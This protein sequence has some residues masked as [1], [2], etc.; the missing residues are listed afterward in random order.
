MYNLYSHQQV[1]APAR[2]SRCKDAMAISPTSC[3][4]PLLVR[5]P[6][7]RWP[8]NVPLSRH[9]VAMRCSSRSPASQDQHWFHLGNGTAQINWPLQV[10]PWHHG[11]NYQCYTFVC[12]LV[13]SPYKADGQDDRLV[14]RLAA[15]SPPAN[16]KRRKIRTGPHYARMGGSTTSS[17]T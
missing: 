15:A 5:Q 9:S 2:R 13:C 8:P 12:V 1:S 16:S 6:W 10:I 14:S 3:E 11:A 4:S 17:D 7:N